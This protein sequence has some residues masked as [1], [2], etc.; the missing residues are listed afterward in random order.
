[1]TAWNPFPHAGAYA[2]DAAS[3]T[4]H[5]PRLHR[6]DCEPLPDD[7]AVLHAWVLFH[8]GQFEEAAQAGLAAGI[9]GITV[10]N[11]AACMYATY[12]ESSEKTRLEL[13]MQAAERAEA[14]QTEAPLNANAWYWQ[15]YAL[16]CYGQGLSVAKALAQGLGN[17]IKMALEQT[18][19]LSPLHA[20]AHIALAT[21]HAEAIDKVGT[22]IGGMT[23]GAKKDTGLAL[24]KEGLR[25]NPESAAAMTDYA[26]GL[27]MLEGEKRMHEAT[28][29]YELA[30]ACQPMDALEQLNVAMAK[31]ELED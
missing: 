10:A 16:N 15:A 7:S 9:D 5:W 12:L 18:I 11:K 31:V 24:F 4:Q 22:L 2:F 3:L 6:G 13:L 1:M 30:A 8:N 21:F 17:T 23:Y 29:L 14:Q 25:L 27:V 26:N 19:R 20:D 28:R